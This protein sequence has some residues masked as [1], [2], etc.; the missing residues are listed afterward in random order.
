M[1]IYTRFGLEVEIVGMTPSGT[2]KVIYVT[3]L[4]ECHDR[5]MSELKADGGIAEIQRAIN[6]LGAATPSDHTYPEEERSR[7]ME[8]TLSA[9]KG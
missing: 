7:T 3:G 9:H 2:P 6:D 1:T 8:R 4:D 5:D